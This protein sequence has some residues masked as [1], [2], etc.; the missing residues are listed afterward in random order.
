MKQSFLAAVL[1]LITMGAKAES[2]LDISSFPNTETIECETT[3]GIPMSIEFQYFRIT[4]I[5][6][7]MFGETLLGTSSNVGFRSPMNFTV[8]SPKGSPA[9][10]KAD[11]YISDFAA[12]NKI[13]LLPRSYVDLYWADGRA[14]DRR[15]IICK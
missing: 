11:F 2:A 1:F 15:E 9:L 13:V 3:Y 14:P 6:A 12:I 4:Q 8:V 10:Y 5:R 7:D